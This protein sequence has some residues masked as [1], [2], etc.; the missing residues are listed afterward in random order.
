VRQALPWILEDGE[1]SLSSGCLGELY[2]ALVHLETRIEQLNRWIEH[3]AHADEQAQ[4]L[5]TIRVWAR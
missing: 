3:I 5:I 2:D 1:N 4:R